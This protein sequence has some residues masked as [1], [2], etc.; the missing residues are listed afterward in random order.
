M[1]ILEGALTKHGQ[2]TPELESINDVISQHLSND[3][4]DFITMEGFRKTIN[5]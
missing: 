2:S 3:K 4:T 5:Q 1:Q